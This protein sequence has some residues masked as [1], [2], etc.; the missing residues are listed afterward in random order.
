MDSTKVTGRFQMTNNEIVPGFDDQVNEYIKIKLQ[1]VNEKCLV[2]YLIGYIDIYN[3]DVVQA[4]LGKVVEAG[5]TQ[6]IFDC[7]QLNYLSSAP[8]GL[9]VQTLKNVK[10]RD[11]N[12]VLLNIQPRVFELFQ[13][14]GFSSFFQV[15]E[16]LTDA[17][18]FFESKSP[19]AFPTIF[20]CPVCN[21]KLRASK[22]GRFRCFECKT[23][24]VVNPEM[25][26]LLG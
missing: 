3:A 8:I 25:Q 22:S 18:D 10:Q 6:L 24:L 23:I 12:L 13:I 19:E 5:F 26:V 21:R 14:L 4:K 11:G 7:R 20:K 9:I 2:L 16:S 1:R 15:S 17:I